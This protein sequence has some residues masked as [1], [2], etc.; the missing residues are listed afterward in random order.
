[1]L[2]CIQNCSEADGRQQIEAW[3][4]RAGGV[5]KN[6]SGGSALPPPA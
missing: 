6:G 1:M 5:W 3:R 2:S 4:R